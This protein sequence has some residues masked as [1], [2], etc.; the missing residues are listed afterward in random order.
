MRSLSASIAP[1]PSL[2]ARMGATRLLA[3]IAARG[4]D[5][6]LAGPILPVDAAGEG[7]IG[8]DPA[9]LGPR[10]MGD[11]VEM[12][13]AEPVQLALIHLAD[14]LDALQIVGGVA[15]RRLKALRLL[16]DR[17]RLVELGGALRQ[18]CELRGDLDLLAPRQRL[19]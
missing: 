10:P 1:A 16:A 6:R 9:D 19:L 18:R 13:D 14:A 3:H 12:I 17:I 8:A 4:K 5:P 2:P 15:P 7:E 11:L